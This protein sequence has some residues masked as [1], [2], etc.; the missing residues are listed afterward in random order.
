MVLGSYQ[1]L[2]FI[3]LHRLFSYVVCLVLRLLQGKP[4]ENSGYKDNHSSSNMLNKELDAL[5]LLLA[6]RRRRLVRLSCR[7]V[8]PSI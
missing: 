7:F 4:E 1:P 3:P 2:L 5:V 6:K 8:V